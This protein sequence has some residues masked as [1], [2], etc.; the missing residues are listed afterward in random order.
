MNRKPIIVPAVRS[1]GKI[2]AVNIR[3]AIMN[4]T[5]A[6]IIPK[7]DLEPPSAIFSIL[8]SEPGMGPSATGHQPGLFS[9]QTLSQCVGL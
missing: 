7:M 9:R 5:I 3:T 1:S 4:E 6:R 8:L 2:L